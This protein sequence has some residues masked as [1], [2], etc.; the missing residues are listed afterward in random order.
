MLNSLTCVVVGDQKL[1]CASCEQ[2]VIRTL[3]A[4]PGA[5][6][7]RASVS[8]QRID[9]LFDPDHLGETRIIERLHLL[10]Y[11]VETQSAGHDEGAG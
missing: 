5:R 10:G 7:V 8:R 6:S 9:V 4:L 3:T 1:R 2:R 11:Q